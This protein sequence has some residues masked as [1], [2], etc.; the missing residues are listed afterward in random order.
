MIKSIEEQILIPTTKGYAAIMK[1]MLSEPYCWRLFV[2]GVKQQKGEQEAQL[3]YMLWELREPGSL[4][5]LINT[6]RNIYNDEKIINTPL[7]L[8]YIKDL[9][10]KAFIPNNALKTSAEAMLTTN[11]DR[12]VGSYPKIND[13]VIKLAKKIAV[14][15]NAET[16]PWVIQSGIIGKNETIIAQWDS[17]Q[18]NKNVPNI[19][20]DYESAINDERNSDKLSII[21]TTIQ[22][23]ENIHI[24]TDGNCRVMYLILN[25]ELIRNGFSPVVLDDPNQIEYMG[26]NELAQQI[27]E[28]GKDA[29]WTLYSSTE[30]TIKPSVNYSNEE[31]SNKIYSILKCHKNEQPFYLGKHEFN[32]IVVQLIVINSE[33]FD[34]ACND[35]HSLQDALQTF[36]NV[37]LNDS[38]IKGYLDKS[39]VLKTQITV[40]Y[41]NCVKFY[42]SLKFTELNKIEKTEFIK[43]A[44]KEQYDYF[45]DKFIPAIKEIIDDYTVKKS[46]LLSVPN[47]IIDEASCISW[48]QKILFDL[49]VPSLGN[50]HDLEPM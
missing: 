26:I 28:Q 47:N 43:L 21:L 39:P 37:I 27:K 12:Y 9:H 11:G 5:A 35:G 15:C 2:D 29:F 36:L 10:S 20:K 7:T 25:K 34:N 19:L 44:T 38:R 13:S 48:Q 18:I 23:L 33:L 3:G 1:S 31:V 14:S 17:K 24:F 50:H 32:N 16:K 46:I 41:T 4:R 8:E 30:H 42:N 40:N 22:T 45:F 49:E 6:A